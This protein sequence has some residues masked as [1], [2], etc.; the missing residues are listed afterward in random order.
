MARVESDFLMNLGSSDVPRMA[1]D[2]GNPVICGSFERSQAQ[3]PPRSW[4]KAAL[5]SMHAWVVPSSS[6]PSSWGPLSRVTNQQ[7]VI[8]GEFASVLPREAAGRFY[9]DL[10]APPPTP[11]ELPPS[12]R[13]QP[14]TLKCTLVPRAAPY[15]FVGSAEALTKVQTTPGGRRGWGAGPSAP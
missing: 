7:G 2:L 1:V 14:L 12:P 4:W 8:L 15:I 11:A 9:P 5:A 10:H 3:G 13:S 6:F